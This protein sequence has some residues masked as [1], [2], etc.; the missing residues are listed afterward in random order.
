MGWGLGGATFKCGAGPLLRT[1]TRG[2]AARG[3]KGLWSVEFWGLEVRPCLRVCGW[4][5]GPAHWRGSLSAEVGPQV[6]GRG[7]AWAL[8]GRREAPRAE[9]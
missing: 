6:G 5:L 1:C 4:G 7:E 2:E 3:K 9:D 8:P